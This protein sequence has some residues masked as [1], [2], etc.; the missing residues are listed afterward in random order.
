MQFC[1]SIEYFWSK[2]EYFWSKLSIFEVNSDVGTT[3]DLILYEMTVKLPL[4]Y[5]MRSEQ[6]KHAPALFW[7]IFKDSSLFLSISEVQIK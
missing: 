5:V 3:T 7:F 6:I 2:S 1:D 4:G